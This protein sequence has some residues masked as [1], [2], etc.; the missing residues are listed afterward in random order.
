IQPATGADEVLYF[1]VRFCLCDLRI[2]RDKDELRDQQA[3]RPREL[4]CNQL[5]DERLGPLAGATEFEHVHSVIIGLDD[6]RQ[7][8]AFAVRSHISCSIYSSHARPELTRPSPKL[9][10]RGKSLCVLCVSL[11]PSALK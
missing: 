3:R 10:I 5:R 1:R 4:T 8:S 6:G 2:E 7:R 11:R 9:S